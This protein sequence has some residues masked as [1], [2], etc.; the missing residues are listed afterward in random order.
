MVDDEITRLQT[1]GSTNHVLPHN[2]NPPLATM[3]LTICPRIIIAHLITQYMLIETPNSQVSP[4]INPINPLIEA[5]IVMK[6]DIQMGSKTTTYILEPQ[7]SHQ[8]MPI[9][10]IETSS[11]Q[12]DLNFDHTPIYDYL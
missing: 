12:D 10:E 1:I 4:S 8:R 2:M 6:S 9:R 7:A 5:M 11:T 3:D